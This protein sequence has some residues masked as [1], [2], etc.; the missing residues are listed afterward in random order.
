MDLEI[1]ALNKPS[2][3]DERVFRM[4]YEISQLALFLIFRIE[5]I[6]LATF[7]INMEFELVLILTEKQ[8]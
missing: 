3:Y 4:T 8:R 7:E 2:T 1:C 6:T 5:F